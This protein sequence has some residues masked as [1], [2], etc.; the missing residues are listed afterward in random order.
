MAHEGNFGEDGIVPY[1]R[2]LRS[3]KNITSYTALD[4]LSPTDI[5]AQLKASN[6]GK[7]EALDLEEQEKDFA[8]VKSKLERAESDLEKQPSHDGIVNLLRLQPNP[9]P[10]PHPHPHPNPNP[11]PNPN[12]SPSPSPSPN[13]NKVPSKP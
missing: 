3:S 2:H 13:P 4:D 9:N 11:N 5:A 10:N 12:P 1:L 6:D 7:I 8:E